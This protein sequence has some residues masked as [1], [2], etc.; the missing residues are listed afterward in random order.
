MAKRCIG[1]DI[2]STKTHAVQLLVSG[3]GIFHV[4]KVFSSLMRR[5][6]DTPSEL[7]KSLTRKHGF[8]KRANV[9]LALSNNDV[10]CATIDAGQTNQIDLHSH[11]PLPPESIITETCSIHSS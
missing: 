10:Y 6:S 7:L 11:F 9:A 8:N 4:E 5:Q 3:K 1:I 2:N